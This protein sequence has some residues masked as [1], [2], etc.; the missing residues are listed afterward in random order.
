MGFQVGM[1]T[2]VP[3]GPFSPGGRSVP[4]PA[5]APLDPA[6]KPF[7]SGPLWGG[8]PPGLL[9]PRTP[10]HPPGSMSEL[11]EVAVHR[12]MKGMLGH[13]LMAGAPSCQRLPSLSR[14]EKASRCPCLGAPVQASACSTAP[15]PG[16]PAAAGGTRI[17][18]QLFSFECISSISHFL[19]LHYP[20]LKFQWISGIIKYEIIYFIRLFI[21]WVHF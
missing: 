7:F 2:A 19:P 4:S 12:L 3:E 15:L 14:V 21:F 20:L 10:C 8:M 13:V 16:V 18:N 5:L 6:S 17:A 1:A 11:L 9:V